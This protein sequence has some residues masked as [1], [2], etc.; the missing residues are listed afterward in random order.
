MSRRKTRRLEADNHGV[1]AAA[2]LL[3]SGG[4]VAFPTETVYGLGADARDDMAVAGI[5]E[6]KERP[7]FNP[8]IVH[9][10]NREAAEELVDFSP[11]ARDLADTFW[12]G[13]LTLVAPLKAGSGIS[14]LVTANGD[15]LAIRVPDHPLA[16]A[17]L[18]EFG[19]PVAA[20]SANP[21][22]RISPTT[23]TH[24]LDGLDGKIDAVIDGG[25]C[26]VGLESTI[27]AADPEPTLLRAGGIPREAIEACL[28]GPL[29][30]AE[31]TDRPQAPGQLVSHYAPSAALR[32][33][34]VERLPDEFLIGFGEIPGDITLSATG[35]LREAASRLFSALHNAD[36]IGKPIAVAPVPPTGLGLAI[37]DRLARAAAPRE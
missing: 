2:K 25:P 18:A 29:K 13:A 6:A 11:Q 27:V 12:P 8:L 17:L 5:F 32:V 1:R 22:G 33:N 9:V 10:P 34:A 4:V 20:P 26:P 19:G 3:S 37:N 36:K 14:R 28:G 35:D 16:T 31:A 23:A 24:V 7:S 30:E 15:A 21:S